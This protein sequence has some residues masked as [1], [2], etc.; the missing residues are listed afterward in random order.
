MRERGESDTD[1][2]GTDEDEE[3]PGDAHVRQERWLVAALGRM[4]ALKSFRWSCSHSLV[5]FEG[6][7][8]ALV[9]CADLEE[10]EVNDNVVFQAAEEDEEAAGGEGKQRQVVVRTPV[11]L[12]VRF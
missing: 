5:S 7:W 12:L 4:E 2:E 11:P 6:V 8:P 10:V 1:L 9:Q 3:G